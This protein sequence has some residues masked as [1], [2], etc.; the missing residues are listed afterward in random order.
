MTPQ[1]KDIPISRAIGRFFGHLWNAAAKPAPPDRSTK[2]VRERT[3]EAPGE[4]D[5]RP[6]VFRRTTIEEIDFRPRDD[7]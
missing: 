7:A 1:D 6:V 4:V 3:E 5:G 2:T